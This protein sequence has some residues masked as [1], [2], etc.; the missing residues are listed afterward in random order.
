MSEIIGVSFETGFTI[1]GA[2][3]FVGFTV[4][5][6]MNILDDYRK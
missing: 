5:L 1:A 3:A 6:A 4:G 2:V